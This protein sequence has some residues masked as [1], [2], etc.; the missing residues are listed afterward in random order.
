MLC[1]LIAPEWLLLKDP[2]AKK[3]LEGEFS[4]E[5]LVELNSKGYN[6]YTWPNYPSVYSGSTVEG[7]DIDT[8][9]WVFVDCDHKAAGYVN[10]EAFIEELFK[11][12]NLPPTRIVD[13]G[14]GVH[15]YWKVTDLD[16]ISYLRF[17]RR[18]CRLFNTDEATGMICQLM[19]VPGYLNNKQEEPK[20]CELLYEDNV[21]YTSEQLDKLIPAIRIEDEQFCQHHYNRI[22]DI[23]DLPKISGRLPD[24]FG[25][26]LKKNKEVNKLFSELRDDRSGGDFRLGHIML[27][28]DFTK[29]EAMNV[30]YNSH[31]A[32][33]RAP[34]HR[35][36]Y[37]H[38]IV[39]KIWTF[40]ENKICTSPTVREILSKGDDT[41][42][43]KRFPCHRLVDDTEH[44]FRLGQVIGLIGGSGVGKTTLT[45]NMFLWFSRNNPDYHHFFFSLEQPSGEVASRIK[46]ICG[47]D[48]SLFDRIH[49]ISNY[50]DDGTYNN[51]SLKTIEDHITAFEKQAS[52]KVGA[53]VVD[54]IGVL[55]KETKNGEND[56]LIG[57]CREMKSLAVRL[58]VMLIMLSQTNRG[59]AGIGDLELDK[60]AAYGT[61]F[62][63]SFVDYCL[64]LWQP[65]KRAYNQGAPTIMA[66]KFVK[67]RHKKQNKD[68]IKEDIRYQLFFDPETERLR[69]M[70][71]DEEK[72]AEFFYNVTNNL[73]KADK[74]TDI[75]PY[76]SRRLEAE[77]AT[78][79]NKDSKSH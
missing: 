50:N 13:S 24:K 22:N 45:L 39:E 11:N 6:I 48:T 10:K 43:G 62:F 76:E 75:V 19:R 51:F 30:L 14:N 63:E 16:A 32:M 3:V 61:V 37:A 67:I 1:R 56:G 42:K 52:K 40:E 31:K 21:E 54:H 49:I 35:Y 53:C 64:C 69:E 17:Q 8:F 44:G 23:E 27:A 59:K 33:Q 55:A 7:R 20:A 36:S 18:L 28:N 25:K 47:E 38:N 77:S 65:L 26:L 73:R 66:L 34:G 12:E 58:N 74:K 78:D 4:D 46:T 41:I 79:N 2:T 68:V 9:K 15:A 70:T 71:Q 57:V 72:S 29:E 5:Q 60:D